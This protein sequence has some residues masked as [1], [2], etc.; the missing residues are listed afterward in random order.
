MYL[1]FAEA[2]QLSGLTRQ[3][4]RKS[5]PLRPSETLVRYLNLY[6]NPLIIPEVTYD[7]FL[8]KLDSEQRYYLAQPTTQY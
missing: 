6:H 5:H 8:P 2:D 1:I 3:P 7:I 4:C